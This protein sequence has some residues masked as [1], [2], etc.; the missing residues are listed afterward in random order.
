MSDG[1]RSAED[2]ASSSTAGAPSLFSDGSASLSDDAQSAL[3]EALLDAVYEGDSAALSKVLS[4]RATVH[5]D[6]DAVDGTGATAFVVAC[7]SDERAELIQPL[8]DAGCAVDCR[9]SLGATTGT[10]YASH[11]HCS[12]RPLVPARTDPSISSPSPGGNGQRRT[13]VKTPSMR[14]SAPQT[15]VTR[16][17]ASSGSQRTQTKP[18]RTCGRSA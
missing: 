11:P 4:Q 1:G 18:W 5:F 16:G 10:G 17:C 8:L 2:D 12:A 13:S 15:S 14:S 7:M 3:E 9:Y 6:I